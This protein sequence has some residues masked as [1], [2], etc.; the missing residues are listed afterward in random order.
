VCN[1]TLASQQPDEGG[2]PPKTSLSS[3]VPYQSGRNRPTHHTLSFSAP[4][5]RGS[6]GH[7]VLRAPDGEAA[8]A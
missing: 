6:G 4:L 1:V 8:P 3:P 7:G 5:L 2:A